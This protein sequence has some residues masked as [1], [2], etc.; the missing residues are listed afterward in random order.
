ML[1]NY[2]NG[3]LFDSKAPVLVHQVNCRGVMGSG[4]A[5]QVKDRYPYVYQEYVQYCKERPV[6]EL[7][8]SCLIVPIPNSSQY[9][10]N[11]FGQINYGTD[12]RKYTSYDALDIA[13]AKL[14]DWCRAHGVRKIALPENMG[15][16]G[17]GGSW[18]VV[19]TLL[20]HHFFEDLEECVVYQLDVN[21]NQLALPF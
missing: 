19:T 21:K 2:L 15:C 20:W 9:V 13:F 17:G 4:V 1:M 11:I 3:N 18:R 10:A 12:G 5:K 16:N 8:G 7:I 14:H 6:N